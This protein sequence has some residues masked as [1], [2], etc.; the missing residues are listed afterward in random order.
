MTN[1]YIGIPVSVELVENTLRNNL[2]GLKIFWMEQCAKACRHVYR[3]SPKSE[4]LHIRYFI[5]SD[6]TLSSEKNDTKII[7]IGRVVLIPW[8]FMKISSL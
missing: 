3:E 5:S 2:W 1:P 8:S 7:E 4:T 6:K